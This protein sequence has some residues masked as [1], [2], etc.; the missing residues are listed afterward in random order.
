MRI[1]YGVPGEG[2]G[3]STRSKVV[4]TYLLEQG[5]EVRVVSS[6][7]AYQFL[8]KS[9]PGRVQ[10]IKGFHLA[11]KDA[12][13]SILRTASLT[14]KSAPGN[15]QANFHRYRTLMEQFQPEVIISDFESFTYLFAKYHRLPIISIDNMQII[16]RCSLDIPIPASERS[17]YLI[18]KNIV[19]GKLPNID[20]YLIATFF[21]LPV[22]K[23]RT[24]LVHPIIR[25]EILE[26]KTSLQD[27]VLVYQTSTSQK[28][29]I[30]L[31]QQLP[32]EKF[33]VY[34]FN[35]E[36]QHGNVQLKAFSESEFIYYLA[37]AKAVLA[38][39]G[40]SLLSEAIY[41]HKPIC[42]IP[43]ANQFEQFLNAAQVQKLGYGRHFPELS[44]DGLKAF[45]YD[46]PIYQ[47]NISKY[48][49]EGNSIL[50]KTLD[51]QLLVYE[52]R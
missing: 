44:A 5:H 46:I 29:L 37:S 6:S 48:H 19:K 31:L 34:G 38:N 18:A 52:A 27:H 35:R 23:E 45:I 9:F 1:L 8:A 41:L 30:A 39:G 22:Q 3:H 7:R 12:A 20:R 36:E 50:F 24:T 26:A 47:N 49:Q 13:V 11:Y 33:L 21:D 28:D 15:L 32:Q 14:L 16:N 25:K 43:L 17:N 2:M 40:F 4:I 42:S 51:K 10:E